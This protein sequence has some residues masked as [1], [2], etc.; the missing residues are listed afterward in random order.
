[1]RAVNVKW[2]QEEVLMLFG[3]GTEPEDIQRIADSLSLRNVC[4]LMAKIFSAVNDQ[5]QQL[6]F[7]PDLILDFSFED[8]PTVIAE[9]TP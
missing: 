1:M 2:T 5:G 9:K 8:I 7:D 3:K 6:V 4:L